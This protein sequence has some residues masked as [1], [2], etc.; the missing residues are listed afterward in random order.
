MIIKK[1]IN[2][3]H[4]LFSPFEK[5]ENFPCPDQNVHFLKSARK[6]GKVRQI[7]LSPQFTR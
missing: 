7:Y 1:G 5:T 4:V 3:T 2:D 6:N